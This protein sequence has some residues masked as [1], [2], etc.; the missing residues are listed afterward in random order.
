M[1]IRTD[2]S[3]TAAVPAILPFTA[4]DYLAIHRMMG[5][6]ISYHI[7]GERSFVCVYVGNQKYNK[8]KEAAHLEGLW[9]SNAWQKATPGWKEQ[10]AAEL[11]R[12]GM[13]Q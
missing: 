4:A 7:D 9:R 12:E 11:V 10:V 3:K 8:D 1:N 2:I 5:H 6:E 13:Q